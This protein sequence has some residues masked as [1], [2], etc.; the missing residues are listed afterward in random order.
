MTITIHLAPEEE[1]KLYQ[2]AVREGSNAESV[3]HDVLVQAL[4]W[5]TQDRAEAV[6]GIQRGI[7]AFEQKRF[8]RFSEFEAKQRVMY[9]LV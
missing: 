3:A 9:F 7:T 5:E 8:R 1:A 6:E 2:K 4:D